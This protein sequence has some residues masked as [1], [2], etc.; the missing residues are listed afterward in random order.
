M[1]VLEKLSD[2]EKDLLA[3]L[4][5]PSGVDQAEFLWY[6]ADHKDGCFRPWP[7]QEKWWRDESPLILNCCA[8]SIGKTLGI[9][10][11]ACVFPILFPGQEMVI[12]AP[13]G[14]LL[15]PL[16][17]LVDTRLLGTRFYRELL[18]DNAQNGITHRPFLAK[19]RNGARIMGK[20]PQRSG[21]GIKGTHPVK[22]EMDE[23]FPAGTL[24]LTKTG[25]KAI[26]KIE[27]GEY[28]WTHKSRWKKVIKTFDRGFRDMVKINGMGHEGLVCSANHKFWVMEEQIS[29]VPSVDANGRG[30]VKKAKT[31]TEPSMVPASELGNG[32][33]WAT[34][35]RLNGSNHVPSMVPVGTS[36]GG[37]WEHKIDVLSEEW[38]W[39]CGLWVAE[40]SAGPTQCT[41]SIHDDEVDEVT[42]VMNRVSIPY[43][44]YSQKT[45]KCTNITVYSPELCKY[46]NGH[47]HK[48]AHN[49]RVPMW[50]LRSKRRPWRQSFFDG[51]VY[52]DGNDFQ[53]GWNYTTVS[54]ELALG[55][56]MLATSLDYEGVGIHFNETRHLKP[57]IIR[58]REVKRG[59]NYHIRIS[60][61]SNET[62]V[63][64]KKRWRRIR[65]VEHLDKQQYCYDI[66]VEEDHSFV[67]E[68]IVCSNSQDY[69]DKGWTEIIETLKKAHKGATWLA[70]GVTR[71][72]HD[73]FY[74]YSQ[75]ASDW[76]VWTITAMSRPTWTDEERQEKIRMYGSIDHPDYRR[77]VRGLHGDTQNPLFVLRRLAKCFDLDHV[78]DYNQSEYFSAKI[79][80]EMIEDNGG[81]ILNIAANV[82][83]AHSTYK[84]VWAGMDVGYVRDPS[85]ILVFS[86]MKGKTKDAPSILKLVARFHLDRVANPQQAALVKWIIEYYNIAGFSLDKTGAGLPLFQDLQEMLD[87]KHLTKIKGYNFSEKVIAGFDES[88]D[89]EEF[90]G[91][92]IADA[93]LKKNVLDYSTDLLR[94]YVDQRRLQ[95]PNDEEVLKE[96]Q[97][98]TWRSI[99]PTTTGQTR[100]YSKG[101]F[102]AL[103][104]A[105]MAVLGHAQHDIETFLR[106]ERKIPR[107]EPVYDI[108]S[109][110]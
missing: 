57:S 56:S 55:M 29:L 37:S 53:N 19:F 79:S 104:A 39:L 103:D 90:D 22:L 46:M 21:V 35:S 33:L 51:A 10:V 12:T 64:D 49:K 100:A 87:A 42:S 81:D 98:Q 77:N 17:D 71:G 3:I 40:G 110:W 4:T 2:D 11:R 102:H 66:E 28:V 94:L 85:E 68:T 8:R 9:Q 86:E 1:S 69:P 52:G 25:Y 92:K 101:V 72:V 32:F 67:V 63:Y 75:P 7:F 16:T 74:E 95:M 14:G 91:D 65:S 70:H 27:I 36:P 105:R 18:V 93:A 24:V 5:D 107:Q 62:F 44:A 30:S 50:V 61:E 89:L 88:V 73:K 20:I 48:G 76:K 78:S 97:G 108:F 13:I 26:E 15:Q 99:T 43:S 84:V 60:N 59:C 82:P 38:A 96:F 6:A 109:Q 80:T 58:G 83:A 23:C 54:K 47:F 106:N 34:P 41:W 31:L 45:S